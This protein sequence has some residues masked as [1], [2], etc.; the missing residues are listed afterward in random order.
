MLLQVTAGVHHSNSAVI[1]ERHVSG[2]LCLKVRGLLIGTHHL[3]A[4]DRIKC[5]PGM[6][7]EDT[8]VWKPTPRLASWKQE[9]LRVIPGSRSLPMS[10]LETEVKK[11]KKKKRPH[12][13]EET[14]SCLDNQEIGVWLTCEGLKWWCCDQ[15]KG[16]IGYSTVCHVPADNNNRIDTVRTVNESVRSSDPC[17]T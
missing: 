12:Q 5:V 14:V 10:E 3:R 8:P 1:Y 15:L 13:G 17:V 9:K 6:M 11:K 2:K 4:F 7:L 16:V